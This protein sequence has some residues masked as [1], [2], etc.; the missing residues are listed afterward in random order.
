MLP[1]AQAIPHHRKAAAL[2]LS[3]TAWVHRTPRLSRCCRGCASPQSPASYVDTPLCRKLTCLHRTAGT[4]VRCS[5]GFPGRSLRTIQALKPDY[6]MDAPGGALR[7][8]L[9]RPGPQPNAAGFARCTAPGAP[10]RAGSEGG[11]LGFFRAGWSTIGNGC[12]RRPAGG[13]APATW[14][15][16]LGPSSTEPTGPTSAPV[17]WP[18]P[19]NS[20]R[21]GRFII[22]IMRCTSRGHHGAPRFWLLLRPQGRG[23][24]GGWLKSESRWWMPLPRAASGRPS[25]HSFIACADP[26]KHTLSGDFAWNSTLRANLAR[27]IHFSRAP[28]VRHS[29]DGPSPTPAHGID[30]VSAMSYRY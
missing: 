1:T 15:W 23:E 5:C 28:A 21:T 20:L 13:S 25:P 18:P 29:R 19:G 22:W 30:V 26:A 12:P 10:H 6:A 8:P 27:R 7:G 11:Y 24:I 9:Q 2:Q 17:D 14:S 16:H 4:S 3:P